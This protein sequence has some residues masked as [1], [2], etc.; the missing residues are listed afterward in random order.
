MSLLFV[1][2]ILFTLLQCGD[3]ITTYLSIKNGAHEANPLLKPIFDKIGEV[4]ALIST[5]SLLILIA[6]FAATQ[7]WGLYALVGMNLV[8]IAVLINN[9]IVYKKAK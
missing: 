2:F 4:P 3:A 1:L 9:F 7:T 5:K 8:Y 6:G